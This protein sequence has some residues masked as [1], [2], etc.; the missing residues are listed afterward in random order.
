MSPSDHGRP[1]RDEDLLEQLLGAGRRVDAEGLDADELERLEGW[2]VFL[3][4]CRSELCDGSELDGTDLGALEQRVLAET[5]RE[6]VSWRGD[7]VLWR[8]FLAQRLRSSAV[9]RVVAASLLLHL[10]AL[11]VLAYYTWRPPEPERGVQVEF[12][13]AAELP[14]RE[15]EPEPPSEV[16]AP[17]VELADAEDGEAPRT[18]AELY[19]A[20]LEATG[21]QATDAR[22]QGDPL[23]VALRC[24]Q[25]LDERAAGRADGAQLAEQLAALDRVLAELSARDGL[26][27]LRSVL[28]S[29]H[30]RAV[31]AQLR[32]GRGGLADSARS[33][34]GAEGRLSGP[35]W[36]AAVDRAAAELDAR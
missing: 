20:R 19:R 31:E 36:R 8:G 29:A 27:A 16:A 35:A 14:F 10:V 17:E 9:L 26:P 21:L 7:L 23:I 6:D 11:P 12:E 25:L 34:V 13:Q 32:P 28:G 1:V 4:E 2:S 3:A 5:T 30:L 24:E 15:S 22:A 33:W 18:A